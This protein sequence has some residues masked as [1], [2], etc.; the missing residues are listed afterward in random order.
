MIDLTTVATRGP[1][2]DVTE[3][4][5]GAIL[6][7]VVLADGRR[8]V[9]KHL[10]HEGDWLT[11]ATGGAGRLR[12]LWET[13]LLERVRPHVDHT[14]IDVRTVEGRDVV[15]MRDARDDLLPPRVA[16]SRSTSRELLGRLAAFHEAFAGEPGGAGFC[17]VGARYAMFGPEFHA[18]DEGPGTHPIADRIATGWGLFEERV[19]PDV[20]A[21]VRTV[22]A[23]PEVL[24]RRL[25]AFP[26]GL[27]HG[28]AKLENLGLGAGGELVA[29]DWGDLT[30]VGPPE[31]DVAW[32]ALKGTVRIGCTPDEVFADFEAASGRPLDPDAVDLAC[33]GSLAQMGFRMAV[34]AYATG[35]EPGEIAEPQLA[36]W[37]DR[38]RAA[39]ERVGPL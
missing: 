33:I 17:G 21:A 2:T 20:V 1:L 13:G 26:S 18:A 16:V 14:V 35:P 15:V 38:V 27:L 37:T 9:L 7:E 19:D 11:R 4:F 24:D 31:V 22:H 6:E 25:A 23:R 34:G 39:L 12:W 28:D 3:A 29:I 5:S 30:G 8:L 36:W 10:P 32:Y